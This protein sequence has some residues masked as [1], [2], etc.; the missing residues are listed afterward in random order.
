[1]LEPVWYEHPSYGHA[2]DVVAIPLATKVRD[3]YKLFPINEIDFDS[4][5]KE[6]VADEAYVIGYLFSATPYLQ[7]PI[8]KKASIASEPDINIDGLPKFLIDTATRPGLSGSPVVMQRIGIHGATSKG[9]MPD[10]LI[11]AIRNFIGVYSGRIGVDEVKAQLGIVWKA[12][13]VKEI[14]QAKQIGKAPCLIGS[15]EYE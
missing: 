15:N 2:V 14:L 7:M 8:W 1:M 4:Q 10:S 5:F 6:K 13:A 12:K 11:G 9:M 3:T